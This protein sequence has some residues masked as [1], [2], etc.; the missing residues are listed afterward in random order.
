M[1]A[2]SYPNFVGKHEHEGIFSPAEVVGGLR[3]KGLVP[4]PDAVVL[5]YQPF[6]LRELQA[7]GVQ[8]TTGY[9]GLWGSLWFTGSG[10]RSVAVVGGFGIGAPAAATVLEELIALGVREF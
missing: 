8:P 7:R 5:T 2:A 4:I 10:V 6:L 3:A 1:P 9:P